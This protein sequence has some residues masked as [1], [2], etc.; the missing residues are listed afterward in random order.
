MK[1][2]GLRGPDGRRPYAVVQ[3]RQENLAQEPVQPGRLPVAHEVARPAA[4][5]P[6]DPRP[7]AGGV[8]APRSGAPQ[9]LRQRAAPP[10]PAL[11]TARRAAGAPGRPDH[12]RRGLSRVG[13]HRARRGALPGAA[14]ALAARRRAAPGDHGA[15]RAGAPS[16]RVRPTPLPAGQ[17]QLRPVHSDSRA[18]SR[19]TNVALP[20]LAGPASIS[21]LGRPRNASPCSMSNGNRPR[22]YP[23][24]VRHPPT[25]RRFS[26]APERWSPRVPGCTRCHPGRPRQTSRP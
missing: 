24:P 23:P 15:G 13:G 18:G 5:V 12:R 2:V 11:P 26:R 22:R 19:R 3:L 9:H 10:R 14:N 4:R 1:P 8:R 25:R 20:M 21:R 6:H 16:H 17:R 7:R